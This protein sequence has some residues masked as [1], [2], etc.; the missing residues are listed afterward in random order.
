MTKNA[1]RQAIDG[2]ILAGAAGTRKRRTK[3]TTPKLEVVKPSAIDDSKRPMREF[4]SDQTANEIKAACAAGQANLAPGKTLTNYRS[5]L[6]DA[7]WCRLAAL[8]EKAGV[9]MKGR[10]SVVKVLDARADMLDEIQARTA[11]ETALL[12]GKA[13]DV[14]K[15]VAAL[16][17]PSEEYLGRLVA[18]EDAGKARVSVFKA[19]AALVAPPAPPAPLVSPEDVKKFDE[20]MAALGGRSAAADAGPKAP[21]GEEVDATAAALV[22]LIKKEGHDQERILAAAVNLAGMLEAY[23][24]ALPPARKRR[25]AGTPRAKREGEV[26]VAGLECAQWVAGRNGRVGLVMYGT[27]DWV[28]CV[29]TDDQGA[30]WKQTHRTHSSPVVTTDAPAWWVAEGAMY[31]AMIEAA[32]EKRKGRLLLEAALAA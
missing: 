32:N 8:E 23:R 6:S 7:K 17:N 28:Y 29:E 15:R 21:T 20:G 31:E 26:A 2:A 22:T 19:L 10:K 11:A 12:D 5:E 1:K 27:N 9:D 16:D 3:V 25:A 4:L 14:V 18:R 30:T 13:G 24:A